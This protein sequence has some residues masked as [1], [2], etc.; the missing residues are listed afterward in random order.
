MPDSSTDSMS[1]K[2]LQAL[3]VD[4]VDHDTSSSRFARMRAQTHTAQVS[5]TE[6]ISKAVAEAPS[7]AEK[8][9]KKSE[10]LYKFLI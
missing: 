8:R 6:E 1:F 4:D 7:T 9:C 2:L 5:L 10:I 3:Q